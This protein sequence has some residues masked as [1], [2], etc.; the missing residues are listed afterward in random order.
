MSKLL[1]HALKQAEGLP[2]RLDDIAEMPVTIQGVRFNTG[3]FGVYAVMTI[4]KPDGEIL[5]VMTSAMLVI[6]A[7]EHALDE[8][9]FPA[10][11]TFNRK[12]RTW[13][14]A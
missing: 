1:D 10:E 9:A 4:V 2:L 5:D 3:Q 12:G 7:L 14:I 6:D 8:E 11:A 13:T